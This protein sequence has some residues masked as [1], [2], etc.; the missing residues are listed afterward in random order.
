MV[1]LMALPFRLHHELY[2][3]GRQKV[4]GYWHGTAPIDL[5]AILNEIY[6]FLLEEIS[7]A[8]MP[9]SAKALVLAAVQP[10]V[11]LSEF[12]G[13][14]H[15]NAVERPSMFMKGDGGKLSHGNVFHSKYG[16]ADLVMVYN[17]RKAPKA[18]YFPAGIRGDQRVKWAKMNGNQIKAYSNHYLENAVTFGNSLHP[19]VDVFL[20]L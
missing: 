10:P 19:N 12:R 5:G 15:I 11:I 14:I 17:Q 9:P 4:I 13:Y 16:G 1:V 20:I 6:S 2:R 3:V 18:T 7:S 8:D